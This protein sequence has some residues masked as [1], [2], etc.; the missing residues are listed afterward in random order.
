MHSLTVK[1]WGG[2]CTWNA[3]IFLPLRHGINKVQLLFLCLLSDSESEPKTV[4]SLKHVSCARAR[5]RTHT[6]THKHT[7]I[8]FTHAC[9][10]NIYICTLAHTVTYIHMFTHTHIHTFTH[11]HTHTHTHTITHIRTNKHCKKITKIILSL[12]GICLLAFDSICLGHNVKQA[13]LGGAQ[14]KAVQVNMVQQIQGLLVGTTAIQQL[15]QQ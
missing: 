7:S 10:N 15:A 5:T 14:R 11:T 6:H 12:C 13:R 9:I 4:S 8:G 2:E 3:E 1:G